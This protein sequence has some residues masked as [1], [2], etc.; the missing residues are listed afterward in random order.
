LDKAHLKDIYKLS[1][2]YKVPHKTDHT[3]LIQKYDF[4]KDGQ[5]GLEDF[6]RM[7]LV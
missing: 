1:S 7:S 3:A 2:K 6:K 4:D 5:I